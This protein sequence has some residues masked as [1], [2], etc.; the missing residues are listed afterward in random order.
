MESI[1]AGFL[2]TFF[3][4]IVLV[5]VYLYLDAIYDGKWRKKTFETMR[6]IGVIFVLLHGV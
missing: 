3:I 6:C 2:S 1:L 5:L 4:G